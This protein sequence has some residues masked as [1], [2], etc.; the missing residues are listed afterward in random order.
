MLWEAA[1]RFSESPGSPG[2]ATF[3][4]QG[5]QMSPRRHEERISNA[6]QASGG[7]LGSSRNRIQAVFV[8]TPNLHVLG[9]LQKGRRRSGT[10]VCCTTPEA[11]D[12]C[13]APTDHNWLAASASRHQKGTR[14][15][16]AQPHHR[17]S[18][19]RHLRLIVE[20]GFG[21]IQ[22]NTPR[23]ICLQFVSFGSALHGTAAA[24]LLLP[25]PHFWMTGIIPSH[26]ALITLLNGQ[27]AFGHV[28]L[29]DKAEFSLETGERIGLIGRN[30]AGK[31]SC[32]RS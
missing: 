31:S 27:L 16:R 10:L 5:T 22:Y 14:H 6:R 7:T 24:R 17:S 3:E 9:V 19:L 26:M 1:K 28:P 4:R 25:R 13:K 23:S 30:G 15:C 20:P 12:P 18:P 8:D 32:S 21:E 29:L 11:S 2:P